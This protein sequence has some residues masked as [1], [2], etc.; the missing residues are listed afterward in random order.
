MALLTWKSWNI[1][2]SISMVTANATIGN[3]VTY[4]ELI[5][6]TVLKL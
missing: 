5:D 6:K 3:K 1:V 2:L 4:N